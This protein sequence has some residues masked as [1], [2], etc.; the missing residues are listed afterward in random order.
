MSI[1]MSLSA[2]LC[3]WKIPRACINSCIALPSFSKQF[4]PFSSGG[5]KESIWAPPNFPTN[6]QHLMDLFYE[7]EGKN[8]SFLLRQER[9]NIFYMWIF[10]LWDTLLAKSARSPW[11]YH[12]ME[13]ILCTSYN[14]YMQWLY[15][16]SRNPLQLETIVYVILSRFYFCLSL[17]Y[18]RVL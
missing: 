5:S 11:L 9:Y 15:I 12:P 3:S 7:I 4:G 6:D 10:T 13:Q 14:L 1:Y 16:F 18:F 2:R 17:S 8:W